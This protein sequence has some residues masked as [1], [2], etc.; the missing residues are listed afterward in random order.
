MTSAG[1][2]FCCISQRAS[3]AMVSS[4]LTSMSQNVSVS[5]IR[6]SLVG[7]MTPLWRGTV[8]GVAVFGGCNLNAQDNWIS[9]MFDDNANNIGWFGGY[10]HSIT[11]GMSP[12]LGSNK[13]PATN[14]MR[15]PITSIANSTW[16]LI[17]TSSSAPRTRTNDPTRGVQN[18]LRAY[19][20]VETKS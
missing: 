10:L 15:T 1:F 8:S 3:F 19:L 17:T 13:Y 11:P 5:G 6:L 2:T 7:W 20:L 12:V 14:G 18:S 9:W 16:I 4:R